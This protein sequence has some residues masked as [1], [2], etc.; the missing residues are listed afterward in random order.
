MLSKSKDISLQSLCK[1]KNI[2]SLTTDT[3]LGV[4]LSENGKIVERLTLKIKIFDTGKWEWTAQQRFIR[5]PRIQLN[6]MI[7]ILDEVKA[8]ILASEETETQ[9]TATQDSIP[10]SGEY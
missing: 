10:A 3:T 2:K 8:E 6:D 1:K 4:R 5:E 7:S 9:D